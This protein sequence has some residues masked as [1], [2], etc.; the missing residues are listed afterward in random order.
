MKLFRYRRPSLTTV[1]GI[2]KAK[3]RVKKE[4]GITAA[5]NWGGFNEVEMVEISGKDERGRALQQ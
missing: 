4:L 2:T 1:L 3:K 5:M